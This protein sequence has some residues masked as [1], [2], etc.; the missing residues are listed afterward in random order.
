MMHWFAELML[1]WNLTVWLAVALVISELFKYVL[2]LNDIDRR[3]DQPWSFHK[4]VRNQLFS[5]FSSLEMPNEQCKI[6]K[7]KVVQ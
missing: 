4:F 2:R 5:V 3:L 7:N 1:F 6:G